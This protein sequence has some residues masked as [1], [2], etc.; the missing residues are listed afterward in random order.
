MKFKI[1]VTFAYHVVVHREAEIEA[2][3]KEEALEKF[4]KQLELGNYDPVDFEYKDEFWDYLD[5][6]ILENE[7]N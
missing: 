3:T 5:Y 4:K 1:P 6:T 7:K 2:K